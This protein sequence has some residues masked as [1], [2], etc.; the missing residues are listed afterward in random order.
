[1]KL[2][3]WQTYL[4]FNKAAGKSLIH[5]ACYQT[6]LRAIRKIDCNILFAAPGSLSGSNIYANIQFKLIRLY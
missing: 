3:S 5:G 4:N 6:E 1:M 2:L